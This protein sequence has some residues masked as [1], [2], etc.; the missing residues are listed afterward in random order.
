[1]SSAIEKKVKQPAAKRPDVKCGDC[2][3]TG[4]HYSCDICRLKFC[5]EHLWSYQDIEYGIT[6]CGECKK[7]RKPKSKKWVNEAKIP[8]DHFARALWASQAESDS[9][10]EDEEEEDEDEKDEESD[11]DKKEEKIESSNT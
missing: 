9:S 7:S 11:D 2:S 10:D 3:K 8:T 1:M 6:A 5:V 4:P